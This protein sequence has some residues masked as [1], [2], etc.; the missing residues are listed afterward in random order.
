MK[1]ILVTGGLGYIGSHT[2]VELLNKGNEVVI[3]DDLSNSQAFILDRIEG[4]TGKRPSFFQFDLCSQEDL[5]MFFE[6]EKNI[7]SVI[8]FAAFKA[9][10]E[11]FEKP[12]AYYRNNLNSLMNLLEGMKAQNIKE[13]VFSSSASVY[14]LP[15][16]LPIKETTPLN[17]PTNPYGKTKLMGE[18]II[19]DFAH[20]FD[21]FK[22]VFL[23]YFNPIGA[24][25]SSLIGEFPQG[26]PN[27]L[28]PYITQTVT[29]KRE[30]LTIFG[31]DYDTHDG[32]CLRDYLHVVDLAEAHLLSLKHIESQEEQV[33]AFNLGLGK[34]VSVLDIVNAFEA[35]NQVKVNHKFG[36][37]RKGDVPE[38]FTDVSKAKAVLGWEAKKSLEDMMQSSWA[39]E[40]GLTE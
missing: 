8:H 27:N 22:A 18:M 7:D 19:E 38:L 33:E 1:K 14:G 37:R 2:V 10:G 4:I 39:F 28:M 31:K 26:K 12:V 29:G 13:L 15:N 6:N 21:G 36:E 3:I 24:H 11:S 23:R 16:E 35:A 30:C 34:G 9:I 32:T 20:T 25:E 5:A 17:K 40:S